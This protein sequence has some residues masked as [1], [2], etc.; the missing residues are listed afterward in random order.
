MEKGCVFSYVIAE[1]DLNILELSRKE[2]F[3]KYTIFADEVTPISSATYGLAEC[4]IFGMAVHVISGNDEGI[5]AEIVKKCK[6]IQDVI[7]YEARLGGKYILFFRMGDQYYLQCDATCSI[8][9][10]Y[11]IRGAFVCSSNERYIVKY[12]N[13]SEE[14]EYCSIRERGDIFQ[15]MPYDITS[16]REIKQLIPNHYLNIN[17]QMP[18]RFINASIKQNVVSVDKG[19]EKTLPMIKNI[20]DFYLR[21]YKIYCPITAGRDSRVVLSFLMQSEAEFSCYTI[22][23][24]EHSDTSQDIAI[25]IEL[26]KKQGIPHRLLEDVTLSDKQI[27]EADNLLGQGRYSKRTLRIGQTILGTFSDGAILNGDIVGQVGKCSLHRDIPTV[28]ATPSYFQCKLHNYSRNARKQLKLWIREIK[29]AGEQVSLFDLFSIEN[30]LGRWAGQI[31]K[32]YATIGQVSLNIFNSRSIIYTW[33]AVERKN[34]KISAIHLNLIR[35]TFPAL[36][37]VKFELDENLLIRIS[38]SSALL[39]LLASYVKFYCEKIRFGKVLRDT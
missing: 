10:F 15:A 31:N 36:L 23:H 35:E 7:E 24:P 25:P 16:Y 34:R 12:R 17:N 19:V 32:V 4:A 33:T 30:R 28:F 39:F 1:D 2:K 11:S 3:G 21:K 29:Q 6:S 18:V 38:K 9:C 14:P 27:F 5:A 20:L 22:K 26:C 37:D 13:I 8:P